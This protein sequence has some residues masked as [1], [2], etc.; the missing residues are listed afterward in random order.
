MQDIFVLGRNRAGQTGFFST[1][2]MPL[3]VQQAP[4]M[5]IQVPGT[6]Y[7]VAQSPNAA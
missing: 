2:Y 4:A 5:G 1:G 6:L 3:F 7:G